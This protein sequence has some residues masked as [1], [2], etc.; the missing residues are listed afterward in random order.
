MPD[1][2]LGRL[3]CHPRRSWGPQHDYRSRMLYASFGTRPGMLRLHSIE[4]CA[5]YAVEIRMRVA[6][7]TIGIRIASSTTPFLKR[8][9][10]D[11]LH[12]VRAMMLQPSQSRNAFLPGCSRGI[13]GRSLR[14]L[15]R[16]S[17]TVGKKTSR[18]LL[19]CGLHIRHFLRCSLL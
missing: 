19:H 4:R 8:I 2:R 14:L 11:M 15:S 1:G 18:L 16:R 9:T 3:F 6:A 12:L 13:F 5:F 7:A 10:C 17:S